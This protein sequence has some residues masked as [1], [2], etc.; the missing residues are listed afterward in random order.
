MHLAGEAEWILRLVSSIELHTR[1]ES[2]P[3]HD[4]DHAAQHAGVFTLFNISIKQDVVLTHFKATTITPV[5]EKSTVTYLSDYC[6]VAL[7]FVLT[8]CFEQL[9]VGHIKARLLTLSN[10]HWCQVVQSGGHHIYPLHTTLS[11]LD[12][13]N[14]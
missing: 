9:V 5:P 1:E 7:T 6:P 10:L 2:H 4:D 12:K 8:K 14:S 11:F 3:P 13:R